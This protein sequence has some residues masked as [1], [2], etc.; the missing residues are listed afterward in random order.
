MLDEM[1]QNKDNV[2]LR[3]YVMADEISWNNT[4]I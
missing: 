4:A 2:Y 3:G 1:F